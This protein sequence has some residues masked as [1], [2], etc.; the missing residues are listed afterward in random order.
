MNNLNLHTI[1]V[2]YNK[3]IND[4]LSFNCIKNIPGINIVIC[5]NSNEKKYLVNKN[6]CTEYSNVN[7][8]NMNGNKGLPAAYNAA[9][10]NIKSN[11]NGW[12]CLFDDDT[13]I[14]ES[15]FRILT[16]YIQK[17]P[18]D[19]YLP[20]IYDEIGLLSPCIMKKYFCHRANNINEI[21]S[22]EISGINSGMAISLRIF[23]DYR[24]DENYFL[25]FVDHAFIRD[26]RIL[27]KKISIL[28]CTL[29]QNF[30]ANTTNIHSL[31][32]RFKILKKDLKY[33]Y[34]K[35]R[36]GL[37]YYHYIILRR[38]TRILLDT[39]HIPALFW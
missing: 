18:V 12:L 6:I 14:P 23:K 25:D 22:S 19:I 37:L 13:F 9:I 39:K 11:E 2:L 27:D 1:I 29:K 31:Q 30:A 16:E 28:P 38:K 34:S 10:N 8:I 3:F 26:M 20:K 33:F 32:T 21:K 7:Y 5:D 35:L 24:Y 4:S 36:F 15:Y 17:N